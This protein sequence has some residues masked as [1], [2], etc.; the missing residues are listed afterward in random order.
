MV[1]SQLNFSVSIIFCEVVAIYGVVSQFFDTLHLLTYAIQIIGIVYS[2]K[3]ASVPEAQLYTR[4]NYFTGESVNT[5]HIPMV[6]IL[7]L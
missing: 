1:P 6:H 3:I 7:A 4:E 5:H 2:A